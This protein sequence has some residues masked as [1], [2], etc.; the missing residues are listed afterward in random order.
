MKDYYKEIDKA[1]KSYE[2]YKPYHQY[3]LD[4]ITDRIDWSWKFR[5]ITEDQMKELTDR[6]VEIFDKY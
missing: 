4:W 6:I 1:L 3:S 2:E 5:K